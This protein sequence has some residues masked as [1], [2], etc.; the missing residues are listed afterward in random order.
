LVLLS[1]KSSRVVVAGGGGFPVGIVAVW[2][3]M[4]LAG[5]ER[6]AAVIRKAGEALEN[7]ERR[8]DLL[9]EYPSTFV[10]KQSCGQR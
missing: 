9:E 8:I 4:D 5:K 2:P 1:I 7:A 3:A 10:A 6:K